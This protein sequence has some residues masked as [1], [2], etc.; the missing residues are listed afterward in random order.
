[1]ANLSVQTEAKF[2]FF[3]LLSKIACQ[4]PK[5]TN[6]LPDNEIHMAR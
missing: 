1:M 6:S 3:N 4:A 2:N 5:P